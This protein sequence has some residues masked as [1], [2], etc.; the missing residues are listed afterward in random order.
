[1]KVKVV[2]PAC[3]EIVRTSSVGGFRHCGAQYDVKT[4][5]LA[6]ETPKYEKMMVKYGKSEAPEVKPPEAKAPEVKP[7]EA[8]TPEVKE[9]GVKPII[10]EKPAEVKKPK[11]R[12]PKKKS[13]IEEKTKPEPENLN[14]NFGFF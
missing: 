11:V 6:G 5:L 3:G 10:E 4:N 2:C 13:E 7:P 12:K 14:G 9:E 8:K 1:M